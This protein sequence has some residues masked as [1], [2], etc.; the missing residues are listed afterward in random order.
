MSFECLPSQQAA[1]V[2]SMSASVE[3]VEEEISK[4]INEYAKCS[5]ALSKPELLKVYTLVESAKVFLREVAVGLVEG[6][7]C[8]PVLLQYVADT[9]PV[10]T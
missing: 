1:H 10:A 4:K 5:N 6:H 9:T 7:D 2:C 3:G 8:Q